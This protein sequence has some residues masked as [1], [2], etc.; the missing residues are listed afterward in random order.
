QGQRTGVLLPSVAMTHNLTP[1]G[2]VN[3]VIDKAGITRAP[4]H[5]TRYDCATWLADSDGV[6]VMEN[7]LPARGPT[8][9]GAEQ[10]TKLRELLT[11]YSARVHDAAG[12]PVS[13]YEVFA[14]RLRTGI[15][16][17]RLAY[18]AW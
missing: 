2:Y 16:P 4:Y 1:Q 15:H 7:G 12:E 8:D 13:R 6:R 18:G 14:D 3:E 11:G 10:V 9:S 5:W 17:A